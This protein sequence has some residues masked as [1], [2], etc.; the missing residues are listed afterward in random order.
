MAYA[1]RQSLAPGDYASILLALLANTACLLI[2]R[3]MRHYPGNA[4]AASLAPSFVIGWGLVFAAIT[5]FR[6]PYSALI[7]GVGAVSAYAL[8]LAFSVL[9]RRPA[10]DPFLVV[11]SA[12][13]SSTL[14][15]LGPFGYKVCHDADQLLNGRGPIIADLR[16]D[17]SPDIEKALVQATLD[18]RRVFHIKQ[19][20]ESLTGRVQIDHLS[21][22]A[23][24]TLAP[25][26]SYAFV[27]SVAERVIAAILLI[28]TL[29]ILAAACLAIKL[30]SPGPALFRQTRVGYRGKP[31]TI[32]KLRTMRTAEGPAS[33]QSDVTQENDPR[34]TRIGSFLRGSRIDELPQLI[35]IIRGEMSFI[36]P[37]PE[38][39]AL[40][41]WYE[42]QLDFYPYRHVILPGITGWAQVRQGHVA[43]PAEVYK[44]LQYDFYYIKNYSFWLDIFVALETVKVILLR[45]GAK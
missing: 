21:E 41:K 18:G 17:I 28:V 36:G 10:S 45:L 33:R 9:I 3:R 15:E 4:N 25:N 32:L 14:K 24:G 22:N 6:L 20:I 16:A 34:I 43:S 27:K 40:S 38:T 26:E 7:L 1:V 2:F 31:F 19:I 39:E 12:A 5:F 13:V 30:D 11:P 23:L 37:R 35:N 29:P 42:E 8:T 44:K